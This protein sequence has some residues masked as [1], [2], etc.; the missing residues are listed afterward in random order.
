MITIPRIIKKCLKQKKQN[1]KKLKRFKV[2]KISEILSSL[3]HYKPEIKK[4]LTI[5][6]NY[7]KFLKNGSLVNI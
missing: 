1:L 3:A 6:L 5:L 2:D 4:E 7:L